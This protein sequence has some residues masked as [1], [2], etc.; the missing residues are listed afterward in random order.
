MYCCLIVTICGTLFMCSCKILF[1]QCNILT[2]VYNVVIALN[3]YIMCQCITCICRCWVIIH[4]WWGLYMMWSF[5]YMVWW[6]SMCSRN[7]MVRLSTGSRLK[8]LM[9]KKSSLIYF[10]NPAF[11]VISVS[12]YKMITLCKELT[13]SYNDLNI[14]M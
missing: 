14:I 9:E 3:L 1:M 5:H 7:F 2:Q 4:V 11:I 6:L 13:T 8:V 10:K 12:Y